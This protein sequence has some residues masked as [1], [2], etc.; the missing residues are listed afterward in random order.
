MLLEYPATLAPQEDGSILV[1][2]RDAPEALTEVGDES[3]AEA[4]A[5]DALI[6]AL[7][8]YIELDRPIPAPSPPRKGERMIALPALI[9]AKLALYVALKEAGLSRVELARRMD[10]SENTVRRLLDLDHRS[11]IDGIE[12]ALTLLGRRLVIDSRSA[13]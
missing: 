4:E 12:A 2:F 13:A 3:A 11:H 8:G 5:A 1:R 7:G 10:V 6:A 9:A